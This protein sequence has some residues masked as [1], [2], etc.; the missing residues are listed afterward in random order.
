MKKRYLLPFIALS[1]LFTPLLVSAQN[2]STFAGGLGAGNAANISVTSPNAVAVDAAG[3]AYVTDGGNSIIRKI[4]PAGIATVIAG[5]GT[6]GYN[7][8]GGLAQNAQ[9]NGP[10]GITIDPAGNIYVADYYNYRVRRIDAVTGIITSVAGTGTSGYNNDNIPANTAQL[11]SPAGVAL[12]TAGNIYIAEASGYRIRKI[13]VSTGIITTIAGVGTS[14]NTGDGAAATLAKLNTPR[15]ISVDIAGNVYIADNGNYKIRRVDVVTGNISTI[16]G[17]GTNGSAGDGA[18]AT[19]AQVNPMGVVVDAN[20]NVYIADNNN[21][22]IRKIDGTTG[23]I[24]TISGTGTALSTGD[25]GLASLAQ[26]NS[27]RGLTRTASGSMYIAEYGGN[28]VRVID[29]SSGIITTLAGNGNYSYGGDGGL[30]VN[31]QL[32][33][34]VGVSTDGAGNVYISDQGNKK[35]RKA[36]HSTNIIDGFAG[37]GVQG[38]SGDGGLAVAAQLNLMGGTAVDA[39][40]NTYIADWN[41]HKIRKVDAVTGNIS[42]IAGT[43]GTGFTGDGGQATAA[44]LYNPNSVAILGNFLYIADGSNQVIRQVDLSTGIIGTV[45][46]TGGIGGLTGDGGPATSAKLNTPSGV[47][48]DTAGN[49]Y[50]ADYGNHK[51]RKV[52]RASG[53]ITTIAGT[54]TGGFSGDSSLA[55]AAQIKHPRGLAVDINNNLYIA[56]V[57]NNRVRKIDA[58]TG[59]IYTIA[60]NGTAGFSGDGGLPKAASLNAPYGVAVDAAGNFYVADQNN[61]R[62]R[63]FLVPLSPA[64][65]I[66]A[67]QN[68]LCSGNTV[69]YTAN[70][71]FGGTTPGYQWTVNGANITG[72]TS[73][74]YSY[75]PVNGDVVRCVLTS[76]AVNA[77]PATITS[78]SVSMVVNTSVTPLLNIVSS[79]DTMCAG[80]QVAF[81]T[82]PTFGGTAPTY[83]WTVN[84]TT[85][86]GATNATYNYT[87]AN[88]DTVRCILTSNYGCVSTP[89]ATSNTKIMTVNPILTPAA[90]IVASQN[91]ICFGTQV[92]YT[93]TPTNG[94]STPNYQWMMNGTPVSGATDTSYQYTPTNGLTISCVLTSNATC[95]SPA[96]ATS[97][98]ITMVVNPV[99]APTVTFTANPGTSIPD[100]QQITFTA[101][102]TNGGTNPQ[103]QWLKNGLNIAGATQATYTAI[104]GTDVLN[105]DQI[106]VWIKN[107]DACGDTASSSATIVTVTTGIG[108]I[109]N[110]RYALSLYPNPNNGGFTL[111]GSLTNKATHAIN[112][113]VYNAIG[114]LI[115]QE[116]VSV[117]NGTL[118]HQ[119]E[120][121][122][123]LPSGNYFLKLNDDNSSMIRFTIS[124]N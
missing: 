66:A 76:S 38:A 79:R 90:S 67:S 4:T 105:N 95:A 101:T 28:R 98:T 6:P 89:H 120:L 93:V 68:N 63:T 18:A 50:I 13:T 94:G 33:G 62:V 2:I 91:N 41:N 12:D 84:G 117:A 106:S 11:K 54:G 116:S 29:G 53:I 27:P 64:I 77:A 23:I 112:L 102:P 123:N 57:D 7:G 121:S 55:T 24:T 69:T 81:T 61:N 108:T 10:N 9:L 17:I 5:T 21:H 107:T 58:I 26:V 52:S 56:D 36:T 8:D 37:T 48:V 86:S 51:I 16:A 74:T 40:G 35:V 73:A 19:L 87:P 43:G 44:N 75:T 111:K 88:N 119:V 60:G 34:P 71:S 96:S 49:I 1:T 92:T 85:M 65:S 47:A 118:N 113:T 82:T 115:H 122:K 100:G 103:Y 22:K 99:V 31:S 30:P 109:G 83:Q 15:S 80:T 97:D 39:N 14:G 78:D 114:Q 104:A 25:G 32:S 59:K 46:G 42:T 110:N 72:A 3:N 70:T 20:N 45:A 124:G